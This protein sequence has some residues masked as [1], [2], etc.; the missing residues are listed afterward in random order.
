MSSPV[1][2]FL[3]DEVCHPPAS[4]SLSFIQV[5][6]QKAFDYFPYLLLRSTSE[7]CSLQ[8]IHLGCLHLLSQHQLV[9][10]FLS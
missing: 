3:K 2:T 5:S 9:V 6:V 4:I 10:N 7:R 8:E 1:F